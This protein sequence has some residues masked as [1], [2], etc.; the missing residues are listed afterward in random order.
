M[1]QLMQRVKEI[2][3]PE[4]RMKK[5]AKRVLDIADKIIVEMQ[6]QQLNIKKCSSYQES[7]LNNLSDVMEKAVKLGNKPLYMQTAK[8]ADV[9]GNWH[10]VTEQMRVDESVMVQFISMIK[11]FYS[12]LFEY[13]NIVKD[14]GKTTKDFV[15]I[16]RF[17]ESIPKQIENLSGDA[18]RSFRSL[19]S[20]LSDIKVT[21]TRITD[22]SL[23]ED[24]DKLSK[25]F[26]MERKRLMEKTGADK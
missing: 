1:S 8:L 25:L 15:S 20:S 4:E 14:F 12:A 13:K 7:M 9:V 11:S 3:I 19:V 10:A 23:P 16:K 2:V 21:Y 26:E 24:D 5:Q 18:A 22:L 17:Q 6:A